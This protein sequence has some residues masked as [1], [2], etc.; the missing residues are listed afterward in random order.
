ME[1][2]FWVRPLDWVYT[3]CTVPPGYGWATGVTA[4]GFQILQYPSAARVRLGWASPKPIEF[5]FDPDGEL[6]DAGP[7]Q[8][9]WE[10]RA[11]RVRRFWDELLGFGIGD[12]PGSWVRYWT[13]PNPTAYE[14]ERGV[15]SE[16]L[17]AGRFEFAFHRQ[18]C[19]LEADGNVWRP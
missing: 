1:E 16:F 11:I 12:L 9:V 14:F 10:V 17:A 2:P 8:W 4:D 6:L 18:W 19:S 13:D 7:A 3:L 5:V 15:C